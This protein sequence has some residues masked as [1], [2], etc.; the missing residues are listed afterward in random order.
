[1]SPEVH[2]SG[3]PIP[4]E[5]YAARRTYSNASSLSSLPVSHQVDDNHIKLEAVSTPSVY[6][7]PSRAGVATIRAP[8]SVERLNS[9][10]SSSSGQYPLRSTSLQSSPLSNHFVGK[11]LDAN[12]V[13]V[14]SSSYASTYEYLVATP[15]IAEAPYRTPSV[16]TDSASVYSQSTARA[17][18]TSTSANASRTAQSG[19]FAS[20][21]V[22]DIP[23]RL[24]V[25]SMMASVHDHAELQSTGA[26]YD[27]TGNGFLSPPLTAL[28]TPRY[29]AGASQT[30]FDLHLS[31]L[32]KRESEDKVD[33]PTLRGLVQ[34]STPVRPNLYHARTDSTSTVDRDEWKKLVLTAAGRGQ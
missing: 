9:S 19:P 34:P 15:T 10:G 18:Y 16:T 30:S 1:M 12:R 23:G 13:S 5:M 6:A 21:S 22:P 8:G 3:L 33:L 29:S 11:P 24:S 25:H 28:P 14:A 31:D 17:E 27:T 4:P 2:A 7:D 20:T 32:P 26:D